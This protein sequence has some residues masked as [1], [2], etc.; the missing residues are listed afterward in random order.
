MKIDEQFWEEVFD[1][2]KMI[3]AEASN[4]LVNVGRT[5]AG[6]PTK[7]LVREWLYSVKIT[8]GI[9]V[10]PN[11]TTPI[12]EQF[13]QAGIVATNFR[14]DLASMIF[15]PLPQPTVKVSFLTSPRSFT[16]H[17]FSEMTLLMNT[18]PVSLPVLLAVWRTVAAVRPRSPILGTHVMARRDG[19]PCLPGISF[20]S[21]RKPHC[22]RFELISPWLELKASCRLAI[23][24]PNRSVDM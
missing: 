18:T 13:A 12:T 7:D 10:T 8:D 1:V 16:P 3:G 20:S 14:V 11:F 6:R 5:L 9:T 19:L 21:R 17:Q 4:Y 23:I 15:P 22:W 2:S 24:L